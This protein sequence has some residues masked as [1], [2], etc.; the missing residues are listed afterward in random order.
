LIAKPG[1]KDCSRKA[2]RRAGKA[3]SQSG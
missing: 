2:L 1:R 3:P